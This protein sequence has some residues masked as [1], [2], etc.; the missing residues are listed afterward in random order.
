MDNFQR[1]QSGLLVPLEVTKAVPSALSSVDNRGWYR[2]FES[3][4]GAWQRNVEVDQNT[5][6]AYWAVFSCVTLIAKDISKLAVWVM[7]RQPSG[8]WSKT[9]MRPILRKPNRFQTRLEFFFYWTVSK[10]MTGNS[11]VLKQRD[12]R[13][14]IVALY[15]LDPRRVTPYVT[16]DGAVWYQLDHDEL[17]GVTEGS[18]RV[19]V[20]ASEIIHDRMYTLFHPLVGISP[21]YACGIPAMQGAA[22]QNN[23]AKFFEN[24]SR[25]GGILT[26]PGAISDDTATRLKEAWQLNYSGANAGKVAVLGDGLKYEQIMLSASESQLIEQLKMTA[27]M[28]CACFHVPGYKIGVGQMPTANNTGVLNQQYYDQCLQWLIEGTEA[29][30]DEGLELNPD[31]EQCWF[32][33]DGLL[34]MDPEARYKSHSEA[35]KGAWMAPNEARAREDLPPVEGGDSPMSQQQNWSL[36]QLAD[37]GAIPDSSSVSPPPADDVPS[38]DEMAERGAIYEYRAY[39]QMRKEFAC[40]A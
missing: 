24:M 6:A 13:G 21:I 18:D 5:V 19:F 33:L 36:A 23:S 16:P 22:I 2:I 8:I 14:F 32:D 3:F 11:Y 7:Q 28:V 10:L 12:E 30:L 9:N 20:P 37:R 31:F 15:V 1:N 26:A 27:E 25:P 39:S 35:I 38:P 4:T 40:E 29:R 17:S 34:R